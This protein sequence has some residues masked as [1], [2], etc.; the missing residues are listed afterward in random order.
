MENTG[1]KKGLHQSSVELLTMIEDRQSYIKNQQ[2]YIDS[3]VQE[4][5]KGQK[6]E[7]SNEINNWK[8]EI[9]RL[10]A[11]YNR[12]IKQLYESTID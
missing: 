6:L 11:S 12:S 9:K 2:E 3:D 7:A 8:E 4:L 10:T 1:I 5:Y